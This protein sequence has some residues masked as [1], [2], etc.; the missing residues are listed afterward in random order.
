MEDGVRTTQAG[1]LP[2]SFVKV[3]RRKI[4]A[5]ELALDYFDRYRKVMNEMDVW[6]LHE[7]RIVC[8][9]GGL[10]RQVLEPLSSFGLILTG[11][12]SMQG[13]FK[14]ITRIRTT[15]LWNQFLVFTV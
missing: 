1:N 11:E 10:I 15:P 6:P 9:C 4:K 13:H 12:E 14:K 8:Q 3:M 7:A 2:R 5:Q